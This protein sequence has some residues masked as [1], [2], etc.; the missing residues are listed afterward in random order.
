[1]LDQRVERSCFSLTFRGME[2]TPEP[3]EDSATAPKWMSKVLW[4]AGLYNVAWGLLAILFPVQLFELAGMAPPNYPALAQCIGMIVG[5]YGVGYAIAA[6]D[7][8]R[9]WPIVLVGLLGKVFGPIGFVW[10]ASRG[11]FPWL[12]G[13]TI[14]TNDLI[15]WVPFWLILAGA[16][17]SSRAATDPEQLSESLQ[18]V[19]EQTRLL[20]GETL[21]D[22]SNRS[23]VLILFL[24]H[25]GCTFCREALHDLNQ[26]ISRIRE[27]GA[28][29]VVVHMGSVIQGQ[30]MLEKYGLTE[31]DQVSDPDRVLFRAFRLQIG[32]LSQLFGPYVWWRAVVDGAVWKHGVG[33]MV[34]N[35]LQMPGVFLVSRGRIVRQYV[36]KTAADR[37]DYAGLSCA[38]S[39]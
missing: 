12:A 4:A 13:V 34:G 39:A 23:P 3:R 8:Y 10:S 32:T 35:G 21:A 33:K 38:L 26:Q 2:M 28:R 25:A 30:A 29:P 6:S 37:P 24:R 18:Q 16:A 7:P 15:W 14:L 17:K 36:H 19:L 20:H 5:V 22:V 9:H 31:I 11:E 27:V 1:M